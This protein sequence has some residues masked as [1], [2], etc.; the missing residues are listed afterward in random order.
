MLQALTQL[1]AVA[2]AAHG[3]SCTA[4]SIICTAIQRHLPSATWM[5]FLQEAS[6]LLSCNRPAC[7]RRLFVLLMEENVP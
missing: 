4:L 6:P 2:Q 3:C 7:W 5:T 1:A